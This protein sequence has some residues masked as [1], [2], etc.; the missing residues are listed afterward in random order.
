MVLDSL[1]CV[2]P[3]GILGSFGKIFEMQHDTVR[4]TTRNLA[5]KNDG[6]FPSNLYSLRCTAKPTH[7]QIER[8]T[9]MLSTWLYFN[10][11]G[12]FSLYSSSRFHIANEVAAIFRARVSLAKLGLVPAAVSLS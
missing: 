4:R 12:L 10:G 6:C 1:F 11:V 9:A 5:Q 7:Q 8:P 3:P 2:L